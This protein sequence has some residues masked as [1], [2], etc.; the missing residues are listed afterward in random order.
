MKFMSVTTYGRRTWH[1]NAR[2]RQRGLRSE[3]RDFIYWWGVSFT[4]A[5]ATHFT[6]MERAL[7]PEMR[8]SPLAQQARDWVLVVSHE[9]AL[10]TCYRREHAAHF[11]RR[12]C[13]PR[14]H[15]RAA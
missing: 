4:G 7:P 3:V 13:G 9:G 1:A 12:K 8:G 2:E 10:I 11:L 14:R 6:V 5:G 15:G